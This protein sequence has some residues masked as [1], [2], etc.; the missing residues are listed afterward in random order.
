MNEP[1]GCLVAEDDPLR[2]PSGAV[3]TVAAG[4]AGGTATAEA[5]AAAAV[6]A[7]AA[8]TAAVRERTGVCGGPAPAW[9]SERW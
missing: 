6:A 7:E 3:G 5:A 9:D 8:A 4:I 1:E 2:R